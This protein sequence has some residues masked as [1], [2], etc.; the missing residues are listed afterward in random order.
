MSFYKKLGVRRVINAAFC[1]TDLGGSRQTKKIQEAY[2]EANDSFVEMKQ[3]EEKAGEF[4]AKVTGAEAAFVSTGAFSA[5]SMSAAA[6]ITRNNVEKMKKLPHTARMKNQILVQANLRSTF[7]RSLEIPGGKIVQVGSKEKGCTAAELE[8]AITK[9]TVAMDYLAMLDSNRTDVLPLSKVIEIG[10]KHGI[11]IIVDAAGQT[12]PTDRVTSIIKMGAD[13][14]CYSGKY[15]GG[16]QSTGFVCGKKDLV[17]AVVQNSFVGNGSWIGRGYK[18]DRQEIVALLVAVETWMKMDHEKE[19]L[20]PAVKRQKY[21]VDNL[22]GV[23]GIKCETQPYNY[24]VVG[25]VAT[26]N[27]TPE[28]TAAIIK[29]F[30]EDDPAIWFRMQRGNTFLMNT[31]ML[32]DGEEKEIVDKI[33]AVFK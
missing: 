9:N 4:L 6:C 16:P 15:F 2:L 33:K 24:H 32:K 21:I 26:L 18:V 17:E 30:R 5:L 20:E 7:D 8:A 1:L 3:L 19:R 29:K 28:E 27:K 14:V 23:P 22:K 10:H 25:I 11:P 31:L 12:Y 13:L